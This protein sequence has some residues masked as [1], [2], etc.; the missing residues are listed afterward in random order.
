M[1]LTERSTLRVE[2][3]PVEMTAHQLRGLFNFFGYNPIGVT[4]H[5]INTMISYGCVQFN[6][7]FAAQEALAELNRVIVCITPHPTLTRTGPEPTLAWHPIRM[8][9]WGKKD[10]YS[11]EVKAHFAQVSSFQP[12]PLRVK[13][14]DAPESPELLVWPPLD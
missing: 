10:S 9:P 5:T 6:D 3:I 13:S 14:R 8:I 7:P 4:M 2:N 12:A 11:K 1:S